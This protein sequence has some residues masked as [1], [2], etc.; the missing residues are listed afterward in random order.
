MAETVSF[1]A[2][3]AGVPIA[4]Y[5]LNFFVR[6]RKGFPITAAA[7]WALLLFVLDVVALI[8]TGDFAAHVTK[9]MQGFASSLFA[10]LMFAGLAL[11]LLNVMWGE[12]VIEQA[13][14]TG[15]TFGAALYVLLS[16]ALTMAYVYA[17]LY[18]FSGGT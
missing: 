7:D 17:H 10:G 9:P 13:Q 3:N 2:T 14:K 8:A 16:I 4:A 11:W 18:V 6:L 5:L 12:G 15:W 1:W